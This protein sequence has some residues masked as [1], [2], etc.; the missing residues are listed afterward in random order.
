MW[1]LLLLSLNQG[2]TLWLLQPTEYKVMVTKGSMTSSPDACVQALFS[3]NFC[4]GNLAIL[5][6][7]SPRHMKRSPWVFYLTTPAPTARHVSEQD[8]GWFWPTLCKF[9]SRGPRLVFLSLCTTDIL[10]QIILHFVCVQGSPGH[11]RMWRSIPGL[12][13]LDT[14]CNFQVVKPKI[15][16]DVAKCPQVRGE[17]G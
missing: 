15:P 2:R 12:N 5:L 3:L 14:S 10:D 9:S 6:C 4:P 16:P 13:P 8:F 1:N 17:R 7:R 11:R